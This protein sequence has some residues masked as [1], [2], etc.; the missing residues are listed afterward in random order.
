MFWSFTAWQ[1]GAAK[2]CVTVTSLQVPRADHPALLTNT[3]ITALPNWVYRTP[4]SLY[5]KHTMQC[6]FRTRPNAPTADC[7]LTVG[8]TNEW[9]GNDHLI[10]SSSQ[11]VRAVTPGHF[12]A[13]YRG[14]ECIGSASIKRPGPSLY[15]MECHKFGKAASPESEKKAKS[16]LKSILDKL[17]WP[18]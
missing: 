10:L 7:V 13:F 2:T 11:P 4:Y 17:S 16:P 5:E 9:C 18:S 14:E 8:A 15:A 6:E 3:L 1:K 12:V